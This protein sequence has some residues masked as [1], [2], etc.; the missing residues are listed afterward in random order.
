M[1]RSR[2]TITA[3]IGAAQERMW[4]RFAIGAT[5]IVL[6]LIGFPLLR[7]PG[8]DFPPGA[9][10]GVGSLCI[11]WMLVFFGQMLKQVR[12][13]IALQSELENSRSDRNCNRVFYRIS[14][15]FIGKYL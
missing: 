7:L 6:W 9:H 11:V 5:P 3:E 14:Q 13:R 12:Q 8:V 1:A 10:L 4:V 15:F 2:E